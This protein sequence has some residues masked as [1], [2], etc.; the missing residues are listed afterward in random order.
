MRAE[1]ATEMRMDT[2]RADAEALRTVTNRARERGSA[3]I[4][5]ALASMIFLGFVFAIID[6]GRALYAYEFVTYAARSGTRYAMVRGSACAQNGGGTSAVIT[7]CGSSTGVSAAQVQTFV[8]G[9]NLPGINPSTI[10]VTTTWPDV[11]AGCSD[12]G[13]RNG[14]GC[15]VL[16]VVQYPYQSTIPFFRITT[17]TLTAESEMVI[18]Q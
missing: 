12:S 13:A 5:F 16:V 17:L 15:P 2:F 9:L 4:E 3:V 11:G 8:Q 6:F 14:P 1:R 10:S 18:S 7:A